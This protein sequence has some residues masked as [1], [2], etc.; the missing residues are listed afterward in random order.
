MARKKSRP[1][2]DAPTQLRA[3]AEERLKATH[4]EAAG[5]SVPD[6][7][8][9]VQELRVHQIELEMQNEELRRTQLE[10]AQARDRYL[11]LHE[12]PRSATCPWTS[13]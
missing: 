9:L 2:K 11:D 6:V 3:R 4:D 12:L 5:T 10:L 7:P 1:A 13:T 8:A